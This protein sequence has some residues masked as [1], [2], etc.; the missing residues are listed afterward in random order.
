MNKKEIKKIKNTMAS[1]GRASFW[2]RTYALFERREN[3]S[4]MS[5]C[6]P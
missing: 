5:S 6:P 3:G 2:M 4:L 1:D